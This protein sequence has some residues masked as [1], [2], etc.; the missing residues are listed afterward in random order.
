MILGSVQNLGHEVAN[1]DLI[2]IVLV[3]KVT[4]MLI[5]LLAPIRRLKGDEFGKSSIIHIGVMAMVHGKCLWKPSL[6]F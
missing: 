6:S 5:T 4:K 3:L 2:L 1:S